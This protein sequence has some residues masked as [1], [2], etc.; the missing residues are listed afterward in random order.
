MIGARL[1]RDAPAAESVDLWAIHLDRPAHEYRRLRSLL[2]VTERCRADR[3]LFERDRHH[4]VVCRG[5][6]R[7]LL[8]QYVGKAPAAIAFLYGERGKPAIRLAPGE[9]D[10]QFNVSH[11]AGLAVCAVT[12]GTGIGVDIE[13][14]GRTVEFASLA[15]RFFS[16]DE[17]GELLA[18]PPAVQRAAFFNCWTRKEAYIK[19]IGDGLSCPLDAF[20]VTLRPG[21][22]AR[23]RSIGGDPVE[24]AR[25]AL[26]AFGPAPGY[27]GAL[28]VRAPVRSITLRRWQGIVEPRAVVRG[29]AHVE[30]LR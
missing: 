6:L 12:A 30:A 10:L 2:D 14:T 9:P 23:L 7:L 27:V 5:T 22:P 16:A 19:A 25:W 1:C 20:S 13:W 8:S 24:A 28:A 3:F 15:G 26:H 11:A 21:E 18:L 4:Y 17:S 29:A